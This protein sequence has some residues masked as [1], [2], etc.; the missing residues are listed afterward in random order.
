MRHKDKNMITTDMN[1]SNTQIF[2]KS[3]KKAIY[4]EKIH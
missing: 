4:S 1:T 3:F 2:K